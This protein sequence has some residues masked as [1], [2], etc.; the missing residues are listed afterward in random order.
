VVSG[1]VSVAR[2]IPRSAGTLNRSPVPPTSAQ[3]VRNDIDNAEQALM[4]EQLARAMSDHDLRNAAAEE[5][6]GLGLGP[7]GRKH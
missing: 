2:D 3:L 1:N 6:P 7:G 5:G 4:F